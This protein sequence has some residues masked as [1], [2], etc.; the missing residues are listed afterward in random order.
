MIRIRLLRI[1]LP[2]GTRIRI[3]IG[4]R[5]RAGT[6]LSTGSRFGILYII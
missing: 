5:L 2:A 4:T 6:R 1:R 3:G